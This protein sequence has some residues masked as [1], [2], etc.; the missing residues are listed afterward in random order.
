MQP[1][2]FFLGSAIIASCDCH[3]PCKALAWCEENN[4]WGPETERQVG[5]ILT[6]PIFRWAAHIISHPI[7]TTIL[8]KRAD[9]EFWSSKAVT[10]HHITSCN[11][12]SYYLRCIT[13]HSRT[14]RSKKRYYTDLHSMLEAKVL[15]SRK[16]DHGPGSFSRESQSDFAPRPRAFHVYY[17]MCIML[18]ARIYYIHTMYKIMVYIKIICVFLY[19]LTPPWS[20]KMIPNEGFTLSFPMAHL[21]PLCKTLLVLSAHKRLMSLWRCRNNMK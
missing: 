5:S 13:F 10:L 9:M 20:T 4:V 8:A 15:W 2:A 6:Y 7:S 19:I 1:N 12:I 16:W 3:H 17:I 11:V 14:D 21:W 18:F